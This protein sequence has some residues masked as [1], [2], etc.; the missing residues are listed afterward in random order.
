[1]NVVN[2]VNVVMMLAALSLWAGSMIQFTSAMSK[3]AK[4]YYQVI[5]PLNELS[6]EHKRLLVKYGQRWLKSPGREARREAGKVLTLSDKEIIRTYNRET[7]GWAAI[8]TSA[9]LGLVASI[10]HLAPT[11]TCIVAAA[12]VVLTTS[13]LCAFLSVKSDDNRFEALYTSEANKTS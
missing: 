1:M 6:E 5:K 10:A 8:V 11:T 2:V 13:F 9:V 12:V 4:N 7:W 3:S